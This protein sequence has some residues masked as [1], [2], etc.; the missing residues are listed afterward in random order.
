MIQDASGCLWC[1]TPDGLNR[2]DSR[3]FKT[4]HYIVGDTGSL[5]NNN[6]HAL[7]EISNGEIWVGT[8]NGVYRFDPC[9]E[10]FTP[11][12]LHHD[13]RGGTCDVNC[14]H[15]KNVIYSIKEDRDR[16]VWMTTYG[17]GLYRYDLV[18]G[19]LHHYVHEEGD[20]SSIPSDLGTK[21]LVDHEGT[22]WVATNGFGLYKY[23][24][25]GDRFERVTIRD[26][27]GREARFIYAL[28]EDSFGNIWVADNGI[29][30]YNPARRTT[31]AYLAGEVRNVHYITE[32]NPGLLYVGSD[33]GLT[34]YNM[35]ENSSE[36]C[37]HDDASP[38]GLNDAFV[39]SILE[40]HEGGLWVGTY[41]GGLNYLSPDRAFEYYARVPAPRGPGGKII[42]EF[43]EGA[44]GSIWIGTDDGGLYRFSP[45]DKRFT[46]VLLDR[47]FPN[48][49]VHALFSD[50]QYLW[51]G[52]YGRGIYRLHL[53]SGQITRYPGD[54]R[55]LDDRSFYS[56]YKDSS[57]TLWVG[58]Q[59]G[60]WRYND[61]EDRFAR[62]VNLGFNSYVERMEEDR[63]HTIWLASQGKGLVSINLKTDSVT[64]HSNE[65][66]GLPE[67]VPTFC[68]MQDKILIGTSGHGLYTYDLQRR[69]FARHP[70]PIFDTH[71]NILSILPGVNEFWLVTNAGLLRYN[72]RDSSIRSYNEEDGLYCQPF[73]SNTCLRASTGHIYIG[74]GNGFNSF[75]PHGLRDNSVVPGILFTDF[76]FANKEAKA[77]KSP[78]LAHRLDKQRSVTLSRDHAGFTVSF[79]ATSF[80]APSKNRYKYMLSGFDEGW[81]Y[82]DNRDNK[83]TYTNLSPGDYTFR[84]MACNNDGLWNPEEARLHV[85]ILP[86]WW[87]TRVMFVVYVLLLLCTLVAGYLLLVKRLNRSHESKIEMLHYENERNLYEA[88]FS[89]FTHVTHEIRT[90]LSLILAPVEAI[91]RHPN[92]PDEIQDDLDVIKKNSERLIDLSNQILDFTKMEQDIY[93]IKNTTFDLVE[94]IERILCRFA[95][96]M[97]QRGIRLDTRFPENIPLLLFSDREALTKI[98]S[99]LLTNALKF[100]RDHVGVAVE[101]DARGGYLRVVVED[102][103]KGISEEE[104]KKM[105]T[106]FYQ[107]KQGRDPLASGFGIGLSIVRLLATR[108][109]ITVRVESEKER[110][111]RFILL[112]PIGSPAADKLPARSGDALLPS[113]PVGTPPAVVA[114][115]GREGTLLIVEDNEEFLVYLVRVFNQKYH[116]CTA[117][118]GQKAL[119]IL[120]ENTIDIIITDL[121]MPVMDGLELCGHVKNDIRLSHIPVILLTAKSDTGSR[122]SGLECGAEVYIEKPVSANYLYAQVMSLLENRNNLKRL[123]SGR[124]FT[125]I[126]TIAKNPADEKWFVKL[127]ECIQ[128]NIANP[129]FSVDHLVRASGTSRTLLYTK[130]KAVTGLTPNDFIRL[131]RLKKAAEYLRSNEHKVNEISLM[132]GFNAPS[133][134]AK[135]FHAQFGSL[136][137]EFMEQQQHKS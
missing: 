88:K 57:G 124:P 81:I 83:A 51:A 49:K 7:H 37:S 80:R 72:T 77:G 56:F 52:T 136:P 36:L 130:V 44:D 79:V 70:H 59:T 128:E 23:V 25:T 125:P 31:S 116:V 129:E 55:G 126:D 50:K 122:V 91:L 39:Y 13:H 117:P 29:F 127:N 68:I 90:P 96:T 20:E 82:T 108:M 21:I 42:N 35:A 112:V 69:T 75:L 10:R 54:T 27:G 45:R 5:G 134:F 64:F 95:P 118:D 87:A 101:E 3:G 34:I 19:S 17:N 28:C 11:F 76:L 89:L 48:V 24:A 41:R 40:D 32:V 78:L 86:P 47:E 15:H 115:A 67:L 119:K 14:K 71:G 46:P 30:K 133:Y 113:L 103:G 4:F 137:R 111:T 131:V 53:S 99:N 85:V 18:D 97:R 92:L 106:L 94:L 107:G 22:V 12:P 121:V 62:V 102:N 93:I 9:P 123:F 2:F 38:A 74:G 60:A 16:R 109:N 61:R 33:V 132:V 8:E 1:G 73:V 105:F 135:C 98:I 43:H 66:T 104:K 110:F 26:E 58:S 100:T 63:F 6:V 84:V 65:R 114:R 120:K